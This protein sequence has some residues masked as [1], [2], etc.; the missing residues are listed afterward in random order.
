MGRVL[1]LFGSGFSDRRESN[2]TREQKP[3]KP[4]S[5][6]HTLGGAAGVEGFQL[7]WGGP[8][9]SVLHIITC[10]SRRPAWAKG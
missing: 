8:V 5:G 6:F 7:C 2:M 9:H 3:K 10:Y 1:G 4:T